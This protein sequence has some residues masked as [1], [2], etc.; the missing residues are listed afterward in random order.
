MW[1]THTVV[2]SQANL[3]G[4]HGGVQPRGQA[5]ASYFQKPL[6]QV[7]EPPQHESG[8][9]HTSP[10]AVHAASMPGK[11]AGHPVTVVVVVVVEVVDVVLV[12]DV[13][14]VL[15]VIVVNVVLVLVVVAPPASA[16]ARDPVAADLAADR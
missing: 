12:V 15:V 3:S 10:S 16:S 6:V 5:T 4:P 2:P 1:V 9:G 11:G 14:K 13:V 7:A 8:T